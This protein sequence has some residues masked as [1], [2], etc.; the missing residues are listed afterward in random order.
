MTICV[1]QATLIAALAA[2]GFSLSWT[3]S[4]EKTTWTEEWRVEGDRLKAVSAS[5]EG[6]GAG[7]DVPDGARMTPEGWIYQPSLPPLPELVLGSSGATGSGWRLCTPE[8]CLEI[9]EDEGQP[10]RIFVADDGRGCE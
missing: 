7:I 9:G 10:V 1:A 2:P 3:H 6:S 4:V 5:V 8:Q